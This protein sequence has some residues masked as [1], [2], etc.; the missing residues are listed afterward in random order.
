M[1]KGYLALVLHAHLPYVRHPEHEN[2]LEERWFFE[3]M[4]ECYIPLLRM[5]EGL[6]DDGVDYGLLISLSPTLVTMFED[7]LLQ[8]RYYRHL[9]NL[10]ALADR[11]IKRTAGDPV[12]GPLARFY[13]DFFRDVRYWYE[14][15][16]ER[17][18]TAAF[19]RLAALGHLEIMTCA[20]T[21]GFLPLLKIN[22]SAVRAQ[23]ATAVDYHRSIFGVAPEG[24]WL[25]ETAVDTETL[26]TLAECGIHFTI[27]SPYQ[28]RAVRK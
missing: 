6:E 2:F 26:E 10:I 8:E 22:A 13:A 16:Y 9:S 25:P 19:R 12:F 18:L 28:A 11:E 5:L 3:A 23:V 21:H 14:E 15:R 24:M 27:L 1:P 17:K 20:A 7:D 4:T